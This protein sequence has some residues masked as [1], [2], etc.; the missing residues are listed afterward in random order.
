MVYVDSR[1]PLVEKCIL[2]TVDTVDIDFYCCFHHALS[3]KHFGSL[4]PTK[5][6]KIAVQILHNASQNWFLAVPKVLPV[7]S[8]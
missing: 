7:V 8:L 4:I 2:S 3:E 6:F 1:R 5:S